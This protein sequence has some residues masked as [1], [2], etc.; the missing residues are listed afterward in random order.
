MKLVSLPFC[1][2]C[3]LLLLLLFPKAVD[4]VKS[5]KD[6]EKRPCRKYH[7][8]NCPAEIRI[9]LK[10]FNIYE[11]VKFN[12][13]HSHEVT[14]ESA[15]PFKSHIEQM[16]RPPQ[17]GLSLSVDTQQLD[18]S[19]DEENSRMLAKNINKSSGFRVDKKLECEKLMGTVEPLE[20]VPKIDQTNSIAVGHLERL[21]FLLLII[22]QQKK[23]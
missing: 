15:S 2:C 11:V 19:N 18:L 12:D 9:C 6:W 10:K 21:I 3:C 14:K 22:Q 4:K 1:C 7:A 23:N 20:S 5:A 13:Q 8:K 17:L 16:M